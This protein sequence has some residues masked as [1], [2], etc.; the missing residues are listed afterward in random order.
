MK[1]MLGKFRLTLMLIIMTAVIIA[2]ITYA[3]SAMPQSNADVPSDWAKVEI[4]KAKELDLVPEEIQ[5]EYRSN[6][7]REE[8]IILE[9][10]MYDKVMESK[11]NLVISRA[12]TSRREVVMRLKL[13]ELISQEMGKPYKWGGTGPDSYDCSG[14]VYSLYGKLG[15]SLPRVASSQAKVGTKVAKEDLTYGDLVFFARDGRNVN[16]VGIYAGNGEFIHAP[17]TGDVVKKTT[18]M[19]GYY[20]KTYYTARRVIN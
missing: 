7:S 14:L 11:D 3:D 10:R 15:I 1:N 8:A 16:H 17:E 12:G 20:A 4:D 18:F 19:S 6:T 2:A 9:R 13:E 5:G